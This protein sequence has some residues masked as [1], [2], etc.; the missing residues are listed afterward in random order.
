MAVCSLLLNLHTNSRRTGVRRSSPALPVCCIQTHEIILISFAFNEMMDTSLKSDLP[1]PIFQIS[2]K[3]KCRISR[4]SAL[5]RLMLIMMTN[6]RDSDIPSNNVPKHRA[7]VDETFPEVTRSHYLK[8][9]S[10]ALDWQMEGSTVQIFSDLECDSCLHCHVSSGT[11]HVFC[12]LG[13][14]YFLFFR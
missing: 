4:H 14:D 3:S 10:F 13:Y 9:N 2:F 7:V 5:R 6:S 12:C 8:Y 11:A 1:Q